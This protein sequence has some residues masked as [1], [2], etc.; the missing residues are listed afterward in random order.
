[1]VN[2]KLNWNLIIILSFI[3][4]IWPIM[5]ML[6]ISDIIGQPFAS[7]AATICITIIW[8]LTVL[9]KQDPQPI[10]TLLAVGIGYGILVILVS[11]IL[12]PILAGQLQGP[13]TNPLAMISVL[14]TNAIWGLFAGGI[15]SILMKIKK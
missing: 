2:K 14:T 15:A 11:G 12:S 9:I 1:M 10:Q 8:I 6:G 7:I 3:A 4:L 5:S 13:L